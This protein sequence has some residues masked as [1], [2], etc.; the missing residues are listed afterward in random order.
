M[1]KVI[2]IILR[3]LNYNMI[4][5]ILYNNIQGGYKFNMYT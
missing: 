3:S 2:I 1:L 5:Y 4:N